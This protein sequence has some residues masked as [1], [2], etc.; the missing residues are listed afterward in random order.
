MFL[1]KPKKSKDK[2]FFLLVISFQSIRIKKAMQGS[3]LM[4]ISYNSSLSVESIRWRC[5]EALRTE[6]TKQIRSDGIPCSVFGGQIRDKIFANAKQL[7]QRSN[8]YFLKEPLPLDCFVGPDSDLDIRVLKKEHMGQIEDSLKK[9]KLLEVSQIISGTIYN[10][11][12]LIRLKVSSPHIF[13][14][15]KEVSMKVDIVYPLSLLG[16]LPDFYSNSLQV[17]ILT[18]QLQ[19]TFSPRLDWIVEDN[20]GSSLLGGEKS[21]YF[22]MSKILNEIEHRET[23]MIILSKEHFFQTF[24]K[25]DDYD[26]YVKTIMVCRLPKML[27]KGWNITNL[28]RGAKSADGFSVVHNFCGGHETSLVSK[29]N[30]KIVQHGIEIQCSYCEEFFSV[31]DFTWNFSMY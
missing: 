15:M 14:F 4:Y 23:R 28:A 20:K 17:D 3:T 29:F 8:V 12:F 13:D 22:A 11:C 5:H 27:K 24:A 18:G 31:F 9:N 2:P 21:L 6:I 26:T 19:F 10:S 25:E 1:E 30:Y 16:T 7:Q